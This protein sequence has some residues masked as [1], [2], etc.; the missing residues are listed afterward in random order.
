MLR[1]GSTLTAYRL[2]SFFELALYTWP[3]LP[4]PMA[5]SST[6]GPRTSPWVLPLRMRSAWNGGERALLDQVLGQG[7]GLGPRVPLEELADD[8][9]ELAAVDQPAAAEVPD[10]PLARA[11]VG[12]Y[13]DRSFGCGVGGGPPAFRPGR[14]MGDQP[15]GRTSGL[16]GGPARGLGRPQRCETLKRVSGPVKAPAPDF[17]I[18]ANSLS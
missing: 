11:E 14:R 4:G 7:R 3:M 1:R 16:C 2:S 18:G 17:R 15:A 8:R 9:V 10:E 6:Y 13:H 5:S 12:T